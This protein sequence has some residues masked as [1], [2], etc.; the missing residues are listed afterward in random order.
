MSERDDDT[1]EPP[2]ARHRDHT[3]R[4][5][6]YYDDATNYELYNPDEDKPDEDETGVDETGTDKAGADDLNA[7]RLINRRALSRG[8]RRLSR[9]HAHAS[10]ARRARRRLPL[11]LR[12]TGR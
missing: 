12:P 2:G 11:L 7:S 6:Y 8:V 1:P 10:A 3:P 4:G 9:S 5:G